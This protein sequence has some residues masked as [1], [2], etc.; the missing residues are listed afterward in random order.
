VSSSAASDL[1]HTPAWNNSEMGT[2]KKT[3]LARCATEAGKS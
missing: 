2:A 1:R 3:D